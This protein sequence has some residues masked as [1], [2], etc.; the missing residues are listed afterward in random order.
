MYGRPQADGTQLQK[1]EFFYKEIKVPTIINFFG[2]FTKNMADSKHIKKMAIF[3][4]DDQ[5]MPLKMYCLQSFPMMTDRE[6]LIELEIKKM[7]DG[8]HLWLSNSFNHP[9]YPIG[10]H[11]IRCDLYRAILFWPEGEGTRGVEFQ[12]MDFKGYFPMRLL[13]MAMS[14]IMKKNSGKMVEKMEK[15]QQELEQGSTTE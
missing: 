6:M 13:N 14:S 3:E 9:D 12:H 7:D 11:A 15:L 4:K 1:M 8:K 5:G 10:D 2:N